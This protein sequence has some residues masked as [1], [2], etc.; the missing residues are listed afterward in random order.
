[1]FG[2]KRSSKNPCTCQLAEH[3]E[4][5][6][7]CQMTPGDV[8]IYTDSV[9]SPKDSRRLVDPL[10]KP[11]PSYKL[12]RAVSLSRTTVEGFT[13]VTSSE[14][15]RFFLKIILQISYHGFLYIKDTLVN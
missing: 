10:P 4:Q 13:E 3:Q 12:P 15:H 14:K 8:L 6:T 7:G 9:K 11:P 1:M 2:P 5:T